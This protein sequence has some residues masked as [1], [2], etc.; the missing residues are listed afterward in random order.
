MPSYD[1]P[2][3]S[4]HG[5]AATIVVAYYDP[6]AADG[7]RY[8]LTPNLRCERIE[9]REGA[10]P[11]AAQFSYVLDD[12]DPTSIYPRYAEQTWPLG[13]DSDHVVPLGAELVVFAVEESDGDDDVVTILFHGHA[14]APQLDV[15][16]E[17][18]QVTFT[19]TSS[20]VRAWDSVLTGAIQRAADDPE[21]GDLVFTQL[22]L[23]FNPKAE[24]NATPQGF[25]VNEGID[26]P[27]PVFLDW[28]IQR[29]PDPRRHWTLGMFTRYLCHTNTPRFSFTV[30]LDDELQAVRPAGGE[31]GV[32]DDDDPSTYTLHPILV[33]DL[34]VTGRNWLEALADTLYRHGFGLC[35][36]QHQ[37][38][39]ATE[40]WPEPILA[41]HVYR[42][43]G[44]FRPAPKDLKLQPSGAFD[45]AR[46]NVA[47]LALVRDAKQAVTSIEVATQPIYHEISVVLA[48]G[49][50]V[51]A[52]DAATPDAFSRA[53][54]ATADAAQR[55]KYRLYVADEAGDGHWD[56]NTN[57]WVDGQS[58]DL[59]AVL[60]GADPDTGLFP[61]VSRNRPALRELLSRDTLGRRL[62]PTVAISVDY[63]GASPAVWDRTGN[64]QEVGRSGWRPL[65]DRLGI[66]LDVD[67]PNAWKVPDPPDGATAIIPGNVV[68]G[69]EAQAAP[70]AQKPRFRLRLTCAIEADVTIGAVAP[71]RAS[72][73]VPFDVRRRV[74]ARDVYRSEIRHESSIHGT[75]TEILRDD[76]EAALALATAIRDKRDNPVVSGRVVVPRLTT[77]YE[78]SDRVRKVAGR[79]VDL[80]INAGAEAGESPRYP[81]VVGV[82]WDFANGQ[83][84][85]HLSL[86]DGRDA[87]DRLLGG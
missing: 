52:G 10:V 54:L 64:W 22:P 73:P 72:S 35:V 44:L 13:L 56:F 40:A 82:T 21:A 78:V 18:Q 38:A 53:A 67:N 14:D 7:E 30:D 71:K 5:A 83:Q 68:R 36:Q 15:G 59:D 3:M 66:L 86:D 23:H 84:R 27:Y 47:A 12:S 4:P 43:D 79:E 29:G 49:F 85:T 58:L 60:G 33:D 1:P 50:E 8:R 25:D 70:D 48:P 19:A 80:R 65:E 11:P 75:E 63:T 26:E 81:L 6:E 42:R 34:D 55:N 76:F 77:L 45:P 31:D 41:L 16:S 24:P 37:L 69:V 74:D 32:I 57:A 46:T 87:A 20:I 61:Y 2:A 9:Y 62:E 28:R 51:A 39:S 17:T